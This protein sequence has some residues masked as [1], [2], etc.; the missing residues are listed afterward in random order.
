MFLLYSQP[1]PYIAYKKLHIAIAI[2]KYCDIFFFRLKKTL[3]FFIIILY[4]RKS[5]RK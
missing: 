1:F 2:E 5:K 4:K 3:L